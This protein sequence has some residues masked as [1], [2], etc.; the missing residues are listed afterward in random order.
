MNVPLLVAFAGL[1]RKRS[2]I[3]ETDEAELML[4]ISAHLRKWLVEV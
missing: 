1:L 4:V 2:S 3:I